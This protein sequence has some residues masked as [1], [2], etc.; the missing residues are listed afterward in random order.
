M[1]SNCEKLIPNANI[2]DIL[3]MVM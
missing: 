1:P 2:S 3:F